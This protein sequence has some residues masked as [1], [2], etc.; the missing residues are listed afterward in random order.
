MQSLVLVLGILL[1]IPIALIPNWMVLD[2]TSLGFHP[3][4]SPPDS[5]THDEVTQ[6][7][8]PE[9]LEIKMIP[10]SA[11][12]IEQRTKFSDEEF[13]R[14]FIDI[15]LLLSFSAIDFL[16]TVVLVIWIGRKSNKQEEIVS[17]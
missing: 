2:G 3:I 8:Q 16:L 14:P 9:Y 6:D 4:F 5:L 10:L 7:V 13:L 1:L 12:D 15:R 11:Y 17:G